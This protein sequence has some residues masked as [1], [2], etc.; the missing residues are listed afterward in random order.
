[1]PALPRLLALTALL[2]T[3]CGSSSPSGVAAAPV[4]HASLGS[5]CESPLRAVWMRQVD[6]GKGFDPF[7]YGAN[8][9][10]M[11]LDSRDGRGPRAI[12]PGPVSCRKPLLTADGSRVVY[13]DMVAKE[14]HVVPFA[15]GTPRKLGAGMSCEVWRDP[16][17]VEWVYYAPDFKP[18]STRDG[19]RMMRL[20]LDDPSVTEPVW[21]STAV[22]P[23]N[24][25]LSADGRYAAGLFPWSTG[26]VLE[27]AKKAYRRMGKGCWASMSPDNSYRMW[28]FDGAHEN[29]LVRDV[30][31][32][33]P[34]PVRINRHPD[35]EKGPVYHPRWTNHPRYLA[36]TGPYQGGQNGIDKGGLGIDLYLGRFNPEGNAL[37]GLVALTQDDPADFFP[38]VWIEGG[39]TAGRREGTG[40]RPEDGAAAPANL[41]EFQRHLQ[42]RWLNQK[43]ND[44]RFEPDGTTRIFTFMERGGA[45]PGRHHDAVLRGGGLDAT[46]DTAPLLG[47][48][49]A[50]NAFTLEM[51]LSPTGRNPD[52]ASVPFAWG[53][54]FEDP[55][56]LLLEHKGH[57]YLRLRTDQRAIGSPTD[58]QL[59]PAPPDRKPHHLVVAYESG[60]LG[61][62]L[63]GKAQGEFTDVKGSLATWKPAPLS[64]GSFT[65][66][67]F[68]WAGRIE[69]LRLFSRAATSAEALALH[70]DTRARMRG[71]VSI[72][73]A[74][75]RAELVESGMT[76]T[77]STIKP[78]RRLLFES[79]YR[80]KSV[81]KGQ[82]FAASEEILVARW[83]I[84]DGKVL[85]DLPKKGDEVE[86]VLEN[87]DDHP[88]LE[89]ERLDPIDRFELKAFLVPFE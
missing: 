81:L 62:W 87:R 20:R 48:V 83:G 41:S 84:L 74:I 34:T 36:L 8:F 80:V 40:P 66:D 63:D 7:G 12:L 65:N 27:L 35:L 82:G 75:V 73:R 49:R 64:L 86:L 32:S 31:T 39:E 11:G 47:A 25:Q 79:V 46:F 38:D 37:D 2:L 17:G 1:M 88:E 13:T 89:G 45:V 6:T 53:H 61:A 69:G 54:S 15:G 67:T 14:F 21:D 16:S 18:N 19:V 50:A 28:I 68:R 44:W 76:S 72:A 52:R 23:D 58:I 22:T 4:A 78:Y 71:R 10:L 60:R 9:S 59:A 77:P 26:G 43:E 85:P 5:L 33:S 42:L 56:L 24:F 3:G 55:N 29:V 57:F 30:N 70:Q 51:V